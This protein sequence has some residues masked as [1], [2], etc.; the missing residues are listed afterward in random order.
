M[1]R[2]PHA[3]FW[4]T[5]AL[6]FVTAT[7][8]ASA[9]AKPKYTIKKVMKDAIKGHSALVKKACKGTATKEE[10]AAMVEYFKALC[11]AKPPKGGLDSWQEKTGAL[12]HAALAIQK[13]PQNRELS[14]RLEQAVECRQCH[15]PHK[16]Q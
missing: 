16:P 5:L 15:N 14:H 3:P 11:D 1:S 9:A 8:V 2:F 10:L 12:Y 4:R 6:A 7:A 13:D